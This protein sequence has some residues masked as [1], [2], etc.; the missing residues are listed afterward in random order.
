MDIFTIIYIASRALLLLTLFLPF[1]F[2]RKYKHREK[3]KIAPLFKSNVRKI[4]PILSGRY[5]RIIFDL[6]TNKNSYKIQTVWA[7]W[8]YL[9]CTFLKKL[10]CLA[11]S[12]EDSSKRVK[13]D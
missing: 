5:L 12:L 10:N 7:I 9:K 13:D 2:S 11:G 6:Q 1:F 3:G 8:N 4:L